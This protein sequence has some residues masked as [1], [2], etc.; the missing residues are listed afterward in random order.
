MVG[1][2]ASAVTGLGGAGYTQTIGGN[3]VRKSLIAQ[4]NE[5]RQQLDRL[6]DD[7]SYNGVNLLKGDKLKLVLQRGLD[8]HPRDPG[9]GFL[10]R[11][12]ADQH[13][14]HLAQHRHRRPR[15]S[16]PTT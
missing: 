2:S 9:E 10:G 4:F 16:S 13:E 11:R 14:R 1:A 5:L 7:A 3:E 6:A 12:A 15:T 8:Q